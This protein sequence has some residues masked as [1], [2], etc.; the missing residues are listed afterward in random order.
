LILIDF[1]GNV[2]TVLAH[3]IQ[4]ICSN[5]RRSLSSRRSEDAH[6]SDTTVGHSI[7]PLVIILHS[8]ATEHT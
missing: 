3:A 4:Y 8:K 6:T 2:H 7:S 5:C 1:V